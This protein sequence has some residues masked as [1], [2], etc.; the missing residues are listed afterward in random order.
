MRDASPE[1]LSLFAEAIEIDPL[2]AAAS[3]SPALIPGP[4]DEDSPHRLGRGGEEV[5]AVLPAARVRG[6]DQS[7]VRLVDQGR[8]LKS[9]VG[10]LGRHAHGGELPQLVVDERKQLGRGLVVADRGRLE[11]AGNFGHAPESNGRPR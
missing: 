5:P 9:L 11:E 3:F 1:M 2:P 8:G 10:R 7:K 4:V 6:A